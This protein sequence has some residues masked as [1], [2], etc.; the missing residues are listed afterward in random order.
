MSRKYI[1]VPKGTTQKDLKKIG[2]FD[3]GLYYHVDEVHKW[4]LNIEKFERL[5]NLMVEE[6]QKMKKKIVEQ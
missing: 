2:G 4:Q 3:L 6:L 5:T 1:D